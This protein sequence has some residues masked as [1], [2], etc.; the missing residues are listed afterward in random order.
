MYFSAWSC[1]ASGYGVNGGGLRR[2]LRGRVGM[3]LP[4][5]TWLIPSPIN[6]VEFGDA[7]HVMPERDVLSCRRLR[8]V[9]DREASPRSRSRGSG[10]GQPGRSRGLV[11]TGS[12]RALFNGVS[13]VSTTQCSVVGAYGSSGSG[14]LKLRWPRSGS[15]VRGGAD[16]RSHPRREPPQ[17]R[18]T[19]SCA[20]P[21]NACI[22]VGYYVSSTSQ[23]FRLSRRG[24]AGCG[25]PNGSWH[26]P[27]E[28]AC[29]HGTAHA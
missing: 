12:T 23:S 24:M 6:S 8:N 15:M 5:D 14:S 20:A 28:F 25:H 29:L 17:P 10:T 19:A 3:A 9:S 2:P 27:V 21:I 11:P 13:C 4:G 26:G 22:A 18:S 7:R 16:T 1:I